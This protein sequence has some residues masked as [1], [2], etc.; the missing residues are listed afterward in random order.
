MSRVRALVLKARDSNAMLSRRHEAYGELVRQ[1]Q[2][3][4]YA[5]AY[6]VLGD[7]HLAENVAQEAFVS[8]WQKLPQLRQPEAFSGWLRR[9]VVSEC[10]RLTR[11]KRPTMTPLGDTSE[12]A[13]DQADPQAALEREERAGE[14]TRAIAKLPKD[15]RMAVVLFYLQERS[16]KEISAFL[17]VPTTTVAKRLYS[18][19]ARLRGLVLG[20]LKTNLAAQRPSLSDTFAARVK[21]GIY[22]DYVGR[23]KFERRPDLIVTIWREGDKLISEGGGQRNEL[24]ADEVFEGGLKTLEFD[25]RGKFL[26]DGRGRISHFVYYEF[27]REMGLARKIAGPPRRRL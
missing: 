8:A 19:R 17:E 14:V 2:D 26:R 1:F 9:I 10:N 13:S 23:Y 22:D 11:G 18:A 25:G 6:A 7:F 20:A 4:A 24:S 12:F 5:C 21:A 27:G 3:M 16:Q 15:E